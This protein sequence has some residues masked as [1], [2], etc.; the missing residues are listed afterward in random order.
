[1]MTQSATFVLILSC[2]VAAI[3]CQT[4]TTD[5][6]NALE[7]INDVVH[8][9]R[10][11][12]KCTFELSRKNRPFKTCIDELQWIDNYP[13]FT[14]N[15]CPLT[16]FVDYAAVKND[17]DGSATQVWFNVKYMN[18]SE[19]C[20]PSII[21]VKVQG[22][23]PRENKT[24]TEYQQLITMTS[25]ESK[26]DIKIFQNPESNQTFEERSD[27]ILD[28]FSAIPIQANSTPTSIL[29]LSYESNTTKLLYVFDH[30]LYTIV[31]INYN[32]K[33]E[34][35]TS[36]TNWKSSSE[37]FGCPQ[38]LCFDSQ[39]DSIDYQSDGQIVLYSANWYWELPSMSPN[40]TTPI[41]KEL[42]YKSDNS[43]PNRPL[44]AVFT[45]NQT[46]FI[47]Y[48]NMLR[49]GNKW[50]DESNSSLFNNLTLNEIDDIYAIDKVV[51]VFNG[52]LMT[53]YSYDGN[54][55]VFNTS[56]LSNQT[57]GDKWPQMFKSIDTAMS[58]NDSVYF[59]RYSFFIK[60]NLD[61][62]ITS[63]PQLIQNSWF[64]CA[65]HD[66]SPMARVWNVS[67]F[68]RFQKFQSRLLPSIHEVSD[69]KPS[70]VNTKTR[71]AL[72][73]IIVMVV[74]LVILVLTSIFV[75]WERRRSV[76]LQGLQSEEPLDDLQAM[77]VDSTDISN[78]NN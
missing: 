28:T 43:K 61:N 32:E 49:L 71:S 60:A 17:I 26:L 20:P 7:L 73:S 53:T 50:Q 65:E 40:T 48:D 76:D 58:I 1:M 35:F 45:I 72:I 56:L 23:L 22:K 16:S 70:P 2:S 11:Q 5:K 51:T 78:T 69:S 33:L 13:I 75:A 42:W 36:L 6:I 63:D 54:D 29:L 9:Y 27:H 68:D 62:D 77:S 67:D 57:I 12:S 14:T 38:T 55:D 41:A 74:I 64:T 44:L 10:G 47:L 34:P 31:D 46:R 19:E 59:T 37:L 24:K 25:I 4:C 15:E 18:E 30:L 3:T 21:S 66:Y 52:N 8:V 39:L